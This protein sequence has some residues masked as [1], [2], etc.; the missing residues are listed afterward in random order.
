MRRFFIIAC[1]LMMALPLMPMPEAEA[2][3]AVS[4]R[5]SR[6]FNRGFNQGTRSVRQS[7]RGFSRAYRTPAR[8]SSSFRN[9]RSSFYGGRGGGIIIRF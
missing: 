6:S 2:G 5:I 8:Y 9:S 7:T 4:R 1:A 3:R